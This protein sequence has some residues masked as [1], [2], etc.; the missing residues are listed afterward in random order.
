MR[1]LERKKSVDNLAGKVSTEKTA[2]NVLSADNKDPNLAEKIQ[3]DIGE[4]YIFGLSNFWNVLKGLAII[5]DSIMFTF[6][7]RYR[8]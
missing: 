5:G 8:L 1:I 4:N 3:E 6:T 7:L 2:G